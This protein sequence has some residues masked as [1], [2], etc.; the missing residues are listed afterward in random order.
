MINLALSRWKFQISEMQMGIA[1]KGWCSCQEVFHS[2]N[3]HH[4][5]FTYFLNLSHI[6]GI[7]NEWKSLYFSLVFWGSTVNLLHSRFDF[8]WFLGSNITYKSPEC[9]WDKIQTFQ[10]YHFSVQLFHTQRTKMFLKEANLGTY[11]PLSVTYSS[12]HV[13]SYF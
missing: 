8:W 7:W 11:I 10:K 12:V 3:D 9:S 2:S 4:I 5:Y 13:S 6:N 1:M